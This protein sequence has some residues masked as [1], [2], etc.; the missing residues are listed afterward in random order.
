MNRVR[1]LIGLSVLVWS[2]LLT[3]CGGNQTKDTASSTSSSTTTTPTGSSEPASLQVSKD[4]EFSESTTTFGRR[5]TVYIKLTQEPAVG[6]GDGVFV[7]RGNTTGPQNP[8]LQTRQ[9]VV[10]PVPP[11]THRSIYQLSVPSGWEPGTYLVDVR[12]HGQTAASVEFTV[13]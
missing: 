2:I 3:G 1:R 10:D 5:D 4:R 13:E 8:D 9:T 6:L 12:V 7:W 11:E